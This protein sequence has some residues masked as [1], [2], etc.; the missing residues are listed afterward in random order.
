MS[1]P[2]D[3]GRPVSGNVIDLILDDH[4][5]FEA[6]MRDLRDSTS[7]R[8][9]VRKAL[10]ALHVAHAEAEEKHVYPQLRRKDAITE[11]EAEHGEE[12]HAEGH[13]AML[14]VLELKGTD[15]QA[16]DDAVEELATALNH[17]LTEEELTILNPAREEISEE[18]L[19]RLGEAFLTERNSQL[20]ADCGDIDNIRRIVAAAE[21]EGLLDDDD[22]DSED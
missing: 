6:L 5:R 11:H 14:K 1:T 16:F 4:R 18:V 17:H 13:E 9:G 10:A 3:L 12:E 20:D 19:V 22:E 7:D 8:D 21:R 2:I 15:T